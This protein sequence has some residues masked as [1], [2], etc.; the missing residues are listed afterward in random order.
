MCFTIINLSYVSSYLFY[1]LW[2]CSYNLMLYLLCHNVVVLPYMHPTF[3]SKSSLL[4]LHTLHPSLSCSVFILQSSTV[5]HHSLE[6]SFFFLCPVGVVN[7]WC[8][9][10]LGCDLLHHSHGHSKGLPIFHKMMIFSFAYALFKISSFAC[11]KW[12]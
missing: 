7:W 12:F 2:T 5:F 10:L 3:T 8:I 4:M 6:A 9:L 11:I 1:P